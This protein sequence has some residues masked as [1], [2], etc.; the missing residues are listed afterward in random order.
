MTETA[1]LAA[2]TGWAAQF[3]DN[4]AG[5]ANAVA[6]FTG[7]LTTAASDFEQLHKTIQSFMATMRGALPG[8]QSGTGCA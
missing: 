3:G 2:S 6:T 1:G 8:G 7:H 4:M 5:A